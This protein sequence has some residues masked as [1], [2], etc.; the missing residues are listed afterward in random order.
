MV[1]IPEHLPVLQP[2][3][4]PFTTRW[5]PNHLDVL[6]GCVQNPLA[7]ARAVKG[8]RREAS[9]QAENEVARAH[10]EQAA[11]NRL[12]DFQ[13]WQLDLESA[14][15]ALRDLVNVDRLRQLNS[16]EVLVQRN[17]LDEVLALDSHVLLCRELAQ[18]DVRQRVWLA[19]RVPAGRAGS[20]GAQTCA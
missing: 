14:R 18:H 2:D 13:R 16:E 19:E 9:I 17:L 3:E 6:D 11:L 7:L 20:D 8:Q 12:A 5:S 15:L 4:K 10:D 1:Q